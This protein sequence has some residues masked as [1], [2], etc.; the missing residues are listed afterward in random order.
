MY[1]LNGGS[2]VTDYVDLNVGTFAQTAGTNR[3]GLVQMSRSASFSM[4]GGELYSSN[5]IVGIATE[6]G[7]A[8]SHFGGKHAVSEG[9]TIADSGFYQLNGGILSARK[10]QVGYLGKLLLPSGDLQN[11][12]QFI[13][14]G[15][16]VE[17]A[18]QRQFGV[19]LLSNT[20]CCSTVSGLINPSNLAATVRFR[21]SH[22]APWEPSSWL[23]IWYWSGTTNGGNGFRIYVGSN[24]Q[25]L[26]A[27]QLRQVVF[28]NPSGFPSGMYSAQIL[29]TGELVPGRGPALN[30]SRS[31]SHLVLSW[32]EG[33]WLMTSTN[34]T[35]PWQY[36]TGA[37]PYTNVFT[38]PRRF[39][40]IRSP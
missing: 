2:L 33:Y 25:G 29:G 38:D 31:R 9:L 5:L 3:M 20:P 17:V 8:F 19:L 40:L 39:F 37:S 28:V 14:S 6:P 23:P 27:S 16:R 18:G 4:S 34:V 1:T 11:N 13:L 35:G 26:T 30:Y 15:G 12:E 7:A 36:L 21:D 22:A 24:A 10:I 32:P